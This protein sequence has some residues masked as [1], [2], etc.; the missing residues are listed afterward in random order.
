MW[1]R[2]RG[3]DHVDDLT[4]EFDFEAALE[5]ARLDALNEATNDLGS[6]R[7]AVRVVEAGV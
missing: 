6:F 4:D 1:D 2:L 7:A 5:V 3:V